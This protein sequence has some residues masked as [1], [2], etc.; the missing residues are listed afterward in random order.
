MAYRVTRDEAGQPH[1]ALTGE[2]PYCHA[3]D[4]APPAREPELGQGLWLV[5]AF[6]VWSGPDTAAVQTALDVAKHFSGKL[7]LGV[8][9]FDDPEECGTWGP[10]LDEDEH[11]PLWVL[12]RDG[13]VCLKR[14][15]LPGI[16]ELA[17]A[18]GSACA[19]S[20]LP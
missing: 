7:E 6:A 11:G 14:N 13:E 12:L 3:L 1:I 18:I 9:P 17:A 15:G 16:D 4:S 19:L 8:R 2:P 10:G 20:E 5:M